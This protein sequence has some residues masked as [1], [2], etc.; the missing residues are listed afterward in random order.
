MYYQRIL[1]IHQL[2]YTYY[3]L[4]RQRL[5]PLQ[6]KI[7]II[8]RYLINVFLTEL[9]EFKAVSLLNVTTLA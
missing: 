2:Y 4:V 5:E 6:A 1:I 9:C 8:L 7:N 3:K